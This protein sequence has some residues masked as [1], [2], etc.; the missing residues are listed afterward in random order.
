MNPGVAAQ[1][2]AMGGM[3]AGNISNMPMMQQQLLQERMRQ[4]QQQQK[5]QM[6]ASSPTHAGSPMSASDFTGSSMRSGSAIPGIARST[7]SPSDSVPSPLASRGAGQRSSSLNQEDYNRLL[8]QQQQQQAA[9][10]MSSQSP[11]FNQGM[12]GSSQQAA[13][14]AAQQQHQGGSNFSMSPQN[15][16]NPAQFGGAGISAPSPTS[17]GQNW[18]ASGQ[19]AYPFAAGSPAT[20]DHNRHMSATPAPQQQPHITPQNTP[21]TDQII[22]SD[23]D[24]FNWSA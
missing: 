14:L 13:M 19:G 7:R 20:S 15:S 6:N 17:G 24:L 4:Q 12:M 5:G 2:A 10:A 21:P 16:A 11:A 22:P 8:L 9:R 1:L 3:G 23:F 18:G